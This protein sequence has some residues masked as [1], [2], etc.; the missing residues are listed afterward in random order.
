MG[1]KYCMNCKQYVQPKKSFHGIAF[2][3]IMIFLWLP[4]LF[5][6]LVLTGLVA[7]AGSTGAASVL[8]LAFILILVAPIVYVIYHVVGKKS[9]C[10]VCNDARFLDYEPNLQAE[11]R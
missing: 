9:R 5:G 8:F 1:R 6:T 11:Q 3:L 7:Y 2:A 10:P 4:S